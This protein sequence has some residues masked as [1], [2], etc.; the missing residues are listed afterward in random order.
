MDDGEKA[1]NLG[2]LYVDD[3]KQSRWALKVEDPNLLAAIDSVFVTVERHGGAAM[4]MGRKL[5]YAY[6][7]NPI[8]H[9]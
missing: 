2:I 8:N 1:V 5:M 7:R 4:P 6:L 3:E 9:P